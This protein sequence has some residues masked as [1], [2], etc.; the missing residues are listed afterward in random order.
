MT[1][2]IL[3]VLLVFSLDSVLSAKMEDRLKELYCNQPP[4]GNQ[5]GVFSSTLFYRLSDIYCCDS[6]FSL[7]LRDNR[8]HKSST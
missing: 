4:G 3:G 2:T 1:E 7:D 6:S 8:E 5:E